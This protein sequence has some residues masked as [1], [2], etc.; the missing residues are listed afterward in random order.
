MSPAYSFPAAFR[1]L[2]VRSR[3]QMVS[4]VLYGQYLIVC[5]DLPLAPQI[6]HV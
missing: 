6:G 4:P 1:P 5:A 2:L 3:I